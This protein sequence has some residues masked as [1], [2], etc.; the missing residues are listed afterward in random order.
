MFTNAARAEHI[1][2]YS[3][4]WLLPSPAG[5]NP[6]HAISGSQISY[7]ICQCIKRITWFTR[8]LLT[9]HQVFSASVSYFLSFFRF[10]FFFTLISLSISP[11]ILSFPPL[12]CPSSYLYF[13]F[14]SSLSSFSVSLSLTS[15]PATPN[16]RCGAEMLLLIPSSV[17]TDGVDRQLTCQHTDIDRPVL[18]LLT[19]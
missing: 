10:T 12:Y 7:T 18:A 4:G 14:I 16:T 9:P 15:R 2:V 6:P 5:H 13:L 3:N 19:T 8:C 1:P 11:P 17:F